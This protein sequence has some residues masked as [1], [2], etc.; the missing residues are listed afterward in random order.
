MSAPMHRLAVLAVVTLALPATA[1]GDARTLPFTYTTD[2]LPGGAAEIDQFIDLVPLRA[3]S[4]PQL[5]EASY[6]ASA[7]QTE[8]ELGFTDR[9]ELALSVT[10]LPELSADLVGKARLAGLGTGLKQRLRYR[11]NEDQHVWPVIGNLAVFLELT[12]NDAFVEA[13]GR[14]LFER[15]LSDRLRI[16]VNFVGEHQWLYTKERN[17]V[18]SASAG[19]AYE[20]SPR[21]RFGIEAWT[22]EEFP[23][24]KVDDKL[25]GQR[26][27][28]YAGPTIV[29]A[30]GRI[31]WTTGVY[32]RLTERDHDLEPGE[33]Y[34]RVWVRSMIG[35]ALSR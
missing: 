9:I 24:P 26:R 4:K 33:P 7:L 2:T 21:L 32:A 29:I 8:I 30:S 31:W 1:R 16:A 34:G 13:E 5:G 35:Y 15:L 22:R 18:F 17:W 25:Y 11:V 12:E 19:A 14:A 6:L 3:A 23:Q 10:V 27:Q 28:V 20:V